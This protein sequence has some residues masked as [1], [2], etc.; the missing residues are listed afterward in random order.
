MQTKACFLPV[1]S[2][3]GVVSTTLSDVEQRTRKWTWMWKRKRK[4]KRRRW[5]KKK[6]STRR[7]WKKTAWRSNP[8][9]N[10]LIAYGPW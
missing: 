6:T 5:W 10:V 9:V 1:T 4:R 2:S 7:W 3:D 8:T